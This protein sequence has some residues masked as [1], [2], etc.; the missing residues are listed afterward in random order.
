MSELE[1]NP[2]LQEH[3]CVYPVGGTLPCVAQNQGPKFVRLG[4]FV[5]DLNKVEAASI[6]PAGI[7][8]WAGASDEQTA[9]EPSYLI[10]TFQ[11]SNQPGLYIP[12]VTLAQF[13]ELAG[14]IEGENEI[15]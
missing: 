5:V 13:E 15:P 10:L 9:A 14:I 6:M 2:L 4:D 12:N 7:K 11:G 8:Y 1:K 3:R